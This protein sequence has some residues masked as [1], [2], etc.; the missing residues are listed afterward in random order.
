[1]KILLEYDEVTGALTDSKGA[2]VVM[3]GMIGFAQEVPKGQV[4]DMMK[5]GMTADDLIKLKNNDVI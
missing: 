5:Q 4:L 2:M 1:M 3:F